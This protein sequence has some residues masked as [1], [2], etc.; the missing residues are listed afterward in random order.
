MKIVIAPDAFKGSLRA[1]EAV[2]AMYRGVKKVFPHAEVLRLPVADG[3]E[4]TLSALITTTGGTSETVSV[5]DPLGRIINASFGVL[6]DQETAVI[7]MAQASG[8][9]LLAE[10]ELDPMK[11]SAYGTGQLIRH[12]FDRGFRKFII[13]LG[14]SATND[15]GTGLL[16]ALGVRFLSEG[17]LL[18]MNGAA[19]SSIDSIDLSQLDRRILQADIRIA[20]DVENPFIG[21]Q[22]ASFVFGPQKGADADMVLRLDEGLQHFADETERLTGIRLHDLQGAGAAGGCAGALIAYAGARLES[23][24]DVVL[25]AIGFVES[26]MSADFILTG[27]GATDRQTLAGKALMGIAKAAKKHGVPAVVISGSVEE[28]AR[29]ELQ[30]WFTQLHSLDDGCTPLSELMENAFGLLECKTAVVMQSM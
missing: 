29:E 6:G 13:G 2:E 12:A 5:Q 16:E 30:K 1:G 24:I 15:G 22:G 26:L 9:M 3:G 17:R 23:G 10:D 21:E 8:L 7:E 14:G 19:L 27:E 18:R 28:E 11:A 25:S 20:S 4:G